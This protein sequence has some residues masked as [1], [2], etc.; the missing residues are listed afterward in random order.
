MSPVMEDV[1]FGRRSKDYAAHRPGFPPSFYDRLE[2]FAPLAGADALDLATG[3]GIV[4]LELAKRGARVTGLDI[5]E[6]QIAAAR[7]QAASLGVTDR[8]RFEVGRA[9]QTGLDSNTFDLLTVGQAWHWFDELAVIREALRLLRPKGLLV[10]AHFSYLAR[11]SEVARATE[12]LILSYNPSWTFADSLGIYPE[13]I[14]A[15]INGGF[16][17]V[18]QFCYEHEQPFTH[19]GWRGRVRTC[20]GVGSGPL[21]PD[22]V[23]AFDEELAALL[24]IRFRVEPMPV[25]HRVWAVVVRKPRDTLE[26]VR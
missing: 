22:Q 26:Q 9:E 2:T 1:D 5:A 7:K 4:A 12:E 17:L 19:R 3:P 14:D 6:N 10:V 16:T 25:R 13:Q 11:H 21:T 18:E 8:T 20:N 15:L 24:A 23:R